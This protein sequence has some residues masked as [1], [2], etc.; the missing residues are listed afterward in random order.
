MP[1]LR[2]R[3]ELLQSQMNLIKTEN[4]QEKQPVIINSSNFVRQDDLVNF[5]K[6]ITSSLVSFENRLQEQAGKIELTIAKIKNICVY[7]DLFNLESFRII[8]TDE[9]RR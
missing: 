1:F 7:E 9:E 6:S 3:I 5:K 8:R 2:K 4:E